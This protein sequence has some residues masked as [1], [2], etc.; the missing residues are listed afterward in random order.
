MQRPRSTDSSHLPPSLLQHHRSPLSGQLW[1]AANPACSRGLSGLAET[2]VYVACV[3]VSRYDEGPFPRVR[4]CR[5]MVRQ[6]L[7]IVRAPTAL[8]NPDRFARIAEFLE[9]KASESRAT[10]SVINQQI[11]TLTAYHKSL[12]CECVTG[13]RRVTEEDLRRAG[14]AQS[15]CAVGQ[16]S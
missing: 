3:G 1:D 14:S 8:H 4:T 15:V 13:Q 5:D 12:I 2:P 6:P 7:D 11:E 10:K 16:T 9:A